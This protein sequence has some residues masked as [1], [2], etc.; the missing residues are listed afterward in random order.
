MKR[1]LLIGAVQILFLANS[2][3]QDKNPFINSED[4]I[5]EGIKLHEEGK[6]KDAIEAYKKV[7]EN[8]SNYYKSL[9]EMSLSFHADSQFNQAL[10][11]CELG[12]KQYSEWEHL[13]LTQY[14][15]ILDDLGQPE[16]ALRIY[17]S[18]LQKYP[19]LSSAYINKGMTFLRLKRFRE[20]EAILQQCLLIDPYASSAHFRLGLAALNQGK[21]VPA[22]LSLMQYLLNN[23]DGPFAQKT[24]LLLN[25][26]AKYTEEIRTLVEIREE[27]PGEN[28]SLTEQI[29]LSKIALDKNYKLSVNLED[30]IVRQIQVMLEKIVF[31]EN[32]PDFWMQ[33]YVPFFKEV[34]NT[35]RLEDMTYYMFSAVNLKHIQDHL[36]K[37]KKETQSFVNNC[38][39]YLNTIRS[40]RQLVYTN[41]KTEGVLYYHEGTLLDARGTKRG[42]NLVGYWEFYFPEGNLKSAGSFNEKSEKTGQWK[43][44]FANGQL[45]GAEVYNNGKQTGDESYYFDNGVLRL[46]TKYADGAVNGELRRYFLIGT[47]KSIETYKDGKLDGVSKEYYSTG[48]LRAEFHTRQDKYDG[49]FRFIHQNG[50]TETE[51]KYIDGKLN[52][53]VRN[54]DEFGVLSSEG[55]YI[56]DER[57]GIW[58]FYH[59]N[60]KIKSVQTYKNGKLEGEYSEYYSNGSLFYKEQFRNGKPEGEVQYFDDDGKVFCIFG[61]DNGVVKNAKY[62]DKQGRKISSSEAKGKRLDLTSF[63]AD[64]TK[65]MQASYNEKGE[66]TGT[67]TYFYGSG[68]ISSVNK[69]ENG[70]LRGPAN[71]WYPNGKKNFEIIYQ[72]GKKEGYY[73]EYHKHGE[74]SIEGWYK[75][76]QQ[77]G[78]WLFYDELGNIISKNYYVDNNLHGLKQVFY[79]GGKTEYLEKYHY[80]WLEELSQFDTTGK[81]I[82]HFVLDNG[83]GKYLLKHLN[84]KRYAEGT[85][86][87]GELHGVFNYYFFDGAAFIKQ[88][89]NQ[90]ELDSNYQCFFHNGTI[91]REG[92]YQFGKKSGEWK[93]YT[94]DG[95]LYYTEAYRWGKL[96]GKR[97]YYYFDGKIDTEIE[98]EDGNKN[99]LLKKF[100]QDGSMIYQMRYKN[101]IPISHSYQDKNGKPVPEIPL[102]RGTGKLM[103]YFS[104]GKISAEMELIDGDLV[105]AHKIYFSNGNLKSESREDYNLS[106]GETKD[107]HFNGKLKKLYT[108]LHNNLHGSYREYSEKGILLEVGE[109]YND[110][111][112]GVW[113]RYDET[114]KLKE[115]RHYYF[116]KLLNIKRG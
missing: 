59:E 55:D 63:Y 81:L 17:D 106:E 112:H 33:Y 38:V 46:K 108:Y 26:I 7:P 114:G 76:D 24:I 60:D 62:F 6:Y 90:G 43:Y 13:F 65:R 58:N 68:K 91:S 25:A 22:F 3:A 85:Y 19:A 78:T 42:D 51:G 110:M 20:A 113:K 50:K 86:V 40:T 2:I 97:I 44:Y 41:R 30:P 92:K 102:N 61:F 101:D 83:N 5:S 103:S 1:I 104:N 73:T 89:F 16:K 82:N 67:E 52:G 45:K 107:Y 72:K 115:I 48:V 98:F 23:P 12:L 109:Y 77:K 111:E 4:V 75:L 100:D 18:T 15:S 54:Y 11:Y 29:I 96:N 31:N 34:F 39:K 10:R 36:K 9:Y 21:I 32:D 64:G 116:G 95:K 35:N 74:I 57:T 80:G 69:Y 66:T 49:P 93:Y 28:Y 37:N 71:S 47:L 27:Q 84:G 87:N 14:G 53:R 99:G 70:E 8:D 88:F 94:E 105:G 79:P 56:N